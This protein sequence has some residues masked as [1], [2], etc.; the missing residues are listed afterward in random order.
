MTETPKYSRLE[1][2]RRWLVDAS[3]VDLANAEV[4][5]IDDLYIANSHLRLRKISAPDV[6]VFKLCKK[7]GG[8]RGAARGALRPS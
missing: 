8:H 2:E 7:Y 1:I 3:A 6:V 4:C 5:E